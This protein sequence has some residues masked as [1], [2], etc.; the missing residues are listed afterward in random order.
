VVAEV[1]ETLSVSKQALQHSDMERCNLKNLKS[2][3]VKE[4]YPFTIS[5]MFAPLGNFIMWIS[6]GLIKI[7]EYKNYNQKVYGLL[8]VKGP[9]PVVS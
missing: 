6:V 9:Q 2:V 4:Q 7:L 3:E 8:Q 1:E 5:N